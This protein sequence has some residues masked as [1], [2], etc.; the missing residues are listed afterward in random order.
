MIIHPPTI[1]AET[2]RQTAFALFDD[3]ISER[4]VSISFWEKDN[5]LGVE[6]IPSDRIQSQRSNWVAHEI[7]V[8][9]W[10]GKYD[11]DYAA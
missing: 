3:L 11:H 2:A 1:K 6:F 9:S 8:R 4:K 7:R 10:S 5:C